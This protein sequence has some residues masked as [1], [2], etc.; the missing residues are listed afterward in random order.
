MAR[1]FSIIFPCESTRLGLFK[2]SIKEYIKY[3]SHKNI[4]IYV[5]S[6][7]ILEEDLGFLRSNFKVKL[8]KYSFPG[9][10]INPST[11]LNLG[12]RFSE[13]EDIIITCPEVMPKTDV[14]QQLSALPRGNYIC[15]VFDLDEL[16][17]E[18][19]SLVNSN[20]RGND[21]SMYFLAYFKKEDILRIN[22]WNEEFMNGLAF[23]DNDFGRRFSQAGLSF[24]CKDEIQGEHQYHERCSSNNILYSNNKLLFNSNTDIRTKNGIYK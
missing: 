20:F 3:P 2:N 22:G 4:I 18:T 9:D 17:N 5:V 15:Q 13:T 12:V 23:E 6:R 14:V 19:M 24:M 16:G 21:P 11:A 10:Y 8:I 7:T 1:T